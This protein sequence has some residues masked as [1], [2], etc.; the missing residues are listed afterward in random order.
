MADTDGTDGGITVSDGS[1]PEPND[2]NDEDEIFLGYFEDSE[3]LQQEDEPN[4]NDPRLAQ[5]MGIYRNLGQADQKPTFLSLRRTEIPIPPRAPKGKGTKQC[6][7]PEPIPEA[8]LLLLKVKHETQEPMQD[9]RPPE[10]EKLTASGILEI[11]EHDPIV[12]FRGSSI[13]LS[14][15]FAERVLPL[16]SNPMGPALSRFRNDDQES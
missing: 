6:V 11:V 7:L 8:S 2:E 15:D 1:E 16:I 5:P 13:P 4:T 12:F 10:S 3:A 9:E 14:A